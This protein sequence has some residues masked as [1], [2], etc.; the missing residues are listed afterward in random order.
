VRPFEMLEHELGGQRY[1]SAYGEGATA[2]FED[3]IDLLRSAL[4]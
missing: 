1:L 2:S 4:A 3:A